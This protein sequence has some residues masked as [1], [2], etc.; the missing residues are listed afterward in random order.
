MK[1]MRCE[2]KFS[3][4][5]VDPIIK[6]FLKSNDRNNKPLNPIMVVI[7]RVFENTFRLLNENKRFLLAAV[8][9]IVFFIGLRSYILFI[10]GY[11][12]LISKTSIPTGIFIYLHIF[13]ALTLIAL[14][15]GITKDSFRYGEIY[16]KNP[17]KSITGRIKRI[18]SNSVQILKKRKDGTTYLVDV[19]LNNV[20][21][22]EL[23]TLDEIT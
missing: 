1:S 4:D 8:I 11:M 22:I 3:Y 14:E 13:L 7:S 19:P 10:F 5:E 15:K 6:E 9:Y 21:R 16:L 2:T 18:D 12:I 23:R 20:S 17:K